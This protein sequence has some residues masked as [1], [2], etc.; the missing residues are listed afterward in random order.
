MKDGLLGPT[1]LV[2]G[3]GTVGE[4]VISFFGF[5]Y[6]YESETDDETKYQTKE[7]KKFKKYNKARRE[8]HVM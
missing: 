6:R 4:P 8:A 3:G 2:P 1:H 7:N 5:D